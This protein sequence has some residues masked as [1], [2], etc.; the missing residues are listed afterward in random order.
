M[1]NIIKRNKKTGTPIY[2]STDTSMSET[3]ATTS[4]PKTYQGGEMMPAFGSAEYNS[5]SSLS[6]TNGASAITAA[7]TDH[8]AETTPETTTAKDVSAPKTK[9]TAMQSVGGITAD[10]AQVA[11]VDLN[12][13]TYDMGSGY[14]LPKKGTA[15]DQN[16][17]SADE[18]AINDAFGAQV[19]SMDRA[20]RDLVNS[21][22]GLYSSRIQAQQEANRRELATFNTMNVRYGTQRYAPGTAQGVLTAD[23]RVGLDRIR[24][25]AAEEAAA[26]AQANQNLSDKKYQAFMDNRKEIKDLR[27]ERLNTIKDL[28]EKAIAAEKEQRDRLNALTDLLNKEKTSILTSAVGNNAPPEVQDLI[29]NAQTTAEAVK[30][31]SDYLTGGTGIVGEYNFYKRDSVSRGLTPLSFDEYQTRDANR[32]LVAA[33]AAVE[34]TGLSTTQQ[35][36]FN[37]I[38]DKYNASTAIKALD[39][40]NSLK[41]ILLDAKADPKSA[42]AQ[43]NLLYSYIKGLDTESAVKEGELDLVKGISAYT[44]QFGTYFTKLSKNVAVPQSVMTDM[45]EGGIKLVASIEDTANRKKKSFEAQAK[46][47]G[48][49]VYNAWKGFDADISSQ[50]SISEQLTGESV[51]AEDTLKQYAGTPQA[52]EIASRITTMEEQL[53]RSITAIEFLQA[54]PEYKK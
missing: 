21:I 19:K 25:I 48:T 35:A 23:E 22:S 51:A 6:S 18:Q 15:S 9:N 33:K 12:Q 50:G 2:P 28:Q 49:Q 27:T 38:V 29:N 43:L 47:N 37:R 31:A 40:A 3:A 4:L 14:F 8:T 34:G 10:E 5:T 45:I 26:I 30:A 16:Q 41:N 53:Q 44:G 46:A 52:D 39:N 36:V 11:G 42:A 1:V 7:V 24:A 54:F 13:Y 20:T 17:M 32:K